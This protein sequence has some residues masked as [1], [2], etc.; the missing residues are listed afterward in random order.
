MGNQHIEK[1]KNCDHSNQCPGNEGLGCSMTYDCCCKDAN[2]YWYDR[3][4]THSMKTI[5]V[6]AAIIHDDEGRIFATQRGYGDWKGWWEFP[7]GKIEPGEN[8]QDAIRREIREELNCE[9]AVGELLTTVEYDY[10][11]FHLSMQCFMCTLSSG[12]PQLLEHEDAR[13]LR[14][15]D[16]DSV[17][18]LPADKGII[19]LLKD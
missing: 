4:I 15:E 17:K 6:V 7:G 1:C 18:W 12:E 11:N 5:H 14:R 3:T 10:P 16:L 19:T 2:I 9:I 8:S 13:W